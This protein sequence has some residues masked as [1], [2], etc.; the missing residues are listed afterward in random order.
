LQSEIASA[1][2]VEGF[3]TLFAQISKRRAGASTEREGGV[4]NVV[5]AM[6][7]NVA[8]SFGGLQALSS[9]AKVVG[10]PQPFKANQLPA[11]QH[12]QS[13]DAHALL[14]IAADQREDVD[15]ELGRQ[16]TRLRDCLIDEVTTFRG[17]TLPGRLAGHEHFGFKDGVSQPKIAGTRFGDGPPVAAGEFIL[18]QPDET[19]LQSGLDLPTWT[20][21]GSFAALLQLEQHVSTFWEAMR[22]EG[23]A[24]QC[25]PEKL[26]ASLVGRQV[27]GRPVSSPPPKFSHVGRAYP[28]W[29]GPDANRH[30]L[31]RRGIPYGCPL[32]EGEPDERERGLM[33]LSYQADI[34][35]QFE[36]VWGHFL[37]CV[38]FPMPGAGRDA[39]VGQPMPTARTKTAPRRPALAPSPLKE[40]EVIRLGLQTFVTPHYAGYFFAPSLSTLTDLADSVLQQPTNQGQGRSSWPS[41]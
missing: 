34:G 14:I 13:Y 16:R 28:A 39:L 7:L 31:I 18:G 17:D 22:R 19:G 33:F 4:L 23:D 24:L 40:G 38:D 37:N 29:V 25:G 8:F 26:A 10:F 27:D 20:A 5:K 30:R 11:A 21:N 41:N 15:A 12:A 9:P 2:E 6:W 1:Q 3:N 36:Y 35:R 32:V